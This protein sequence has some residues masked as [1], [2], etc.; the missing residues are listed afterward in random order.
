MFF[1]VVPLLLASASPGATDGP[2]F[3]VEAS[4]M[5]RPR[6]DL[7]CDQRGPLFGKCFSIETERGLKLTSHEVLERLPQTSRVRMLRRAMTARIEGMRR[8]LRGSA[9]RSLAQSLEGTP[10]RAASLPL[11]MQASDDDMAFVRHRQRA[12]PIAEEDELIAR[13]IERLNDSLP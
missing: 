9:R 7:L 11:R 4:V 8:L 6:E 2:L 3:F 1:I 10:A 12:L 13:E 5:D